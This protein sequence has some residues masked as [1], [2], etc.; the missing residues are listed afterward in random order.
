MDETAA[1]DSSAEMLDGL[2]Q[3]IIEFRKEAR[4]QKN[5][6]KSDLIRDELLK[7]GVQIKDGK[8]GASWS[9]L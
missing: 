7:L 2:M 8:E 9:K 1:N 3:M 5:W 4:E 6:A